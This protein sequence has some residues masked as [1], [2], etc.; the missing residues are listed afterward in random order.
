VKL[1]DMNP[2]GNAT[3]EKVAAAK[4]NLADRKV[5]KKEVGKGLKQK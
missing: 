3:N 5:W 4:K 2:T 1:A